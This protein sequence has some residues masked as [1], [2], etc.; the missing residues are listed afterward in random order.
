MGGQIVDASLV[1]APKQ[2]ST[3]QGKRRRRS[4][5]TGFLRTDSQASKAQAQELRR[6][7]SN[8][9]KPS[10]DDPEEFRQTCRAL[11]DRLERQGGASFADY[12]ASA[13]RLQLNRK[14]PQGYKVF[15]DLLSGH[16]PIG[17]A[18]TMRGVQGARPPIYVWE[19][20]MAFARP[21]VIG[22]ARSARSAGNSVGRR[23]RT[24]FSTS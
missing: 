17:S 18:N 11:A 15:L 1:A 24:Q 16:S 6:P 3:T 8:S 19:R 14:D 4:R 22:R 12:G 20:E 5:T 7:Q 13:N 21:S 9:A 23:S 2:H 10:R